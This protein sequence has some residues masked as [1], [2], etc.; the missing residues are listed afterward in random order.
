[1]KKLSFFC[2]IIK[3]GQ[4]EQLKENLFKT[5]GSA[6]SQFIVNAA[7][8]SQSASMFL[9]LTSVCFKFQH[10][11]L[12]L[13]IFSSEQLNNRE[14]F[15]PYSYNKTILHNV[16]LNQESFSEINKLRVLVFWGVF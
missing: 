1:M 5:S 14:T 2:K 8:L 3:Q 16:S 12:S 4:Q 13:S 7:D 6:H 10:L 11:K 9:Y 15:F